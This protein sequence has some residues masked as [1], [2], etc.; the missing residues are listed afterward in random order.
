MWTWTRHKETVQTL[1]STSGPGIYSEDQSGRGSSTGTVPP[2]VDSDTLRRHRVPDLLRSRLWVNT[3]DPNSSLRR[4]WG[5]LDLCDTHKSR[6]S[7]EETRDVGPPLHYGRVRPRTVG[8]PP[9]T[10]VSSVSSSYFYALPNSSVIPYPPR[11]FLLVPT[12]R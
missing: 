9:N 12:L 3:V 8:C 7:R 2:V 11:S 4:V 10:F 5:L 6:R 1:R